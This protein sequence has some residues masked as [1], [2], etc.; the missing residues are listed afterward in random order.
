MP[1]ATASASARK[2]CTR[3]SE[4]PHVNRLLSVSACSS[5]APFASNAT[6]KVT[7][8]RCSPERSSSA[9]TSERKSW[10]LA[11]HLSLRLVGLEG[12]KQ[13]D[14]CHFSP[15][16]CLLCLLEGADE[17]GTRPRPLSSARSRTRGTSDSER[18]CLILPACRT[19]VSLSIKLRQRRV[20][21]N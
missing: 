12:D 17:P 7:D 3:S 9:T 1:T 2:R 13:E 14:A 16:L 11:R 10:R 21:E 6:F 8:G 4:A 15:C 18:S 19:P 5:T 20:Y